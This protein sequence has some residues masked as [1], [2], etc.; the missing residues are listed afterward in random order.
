MLM[1]IITTTMSIGLHFL[2]IKVMEMTLSHAKHM[3][4]VLVVML[5]NAI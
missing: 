5:R 3:D 2:I 1:K 4:T